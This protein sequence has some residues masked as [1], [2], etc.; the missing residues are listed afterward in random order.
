V[1]SDGAV[2][3]APRADLVRELDTARCWALAADGEGCWLGT[4]NP[5]CVYRWR[6]GGEIEL[7]AETDSFMVLSLLPD[8]E[9][10]VLAGTGPDGRVLQIGADG[11]T[12][13]TW[14][15]QARYVWALE[16]DGDGAVMAGTGPD[17][18]VFRLGE[19]PELMAQI[20]QPHVLDLLFDGERLLA[21]GGDNEGGV[22][23]ITGGGW[24]RDIF[25][26]EE[27]ACTG[28]AVDEQGRLI[29]STAESGKAWVL[30]PDGDCQEVLESEGDLL[31]VA[32]AGGRAW[33]ATAHDGELVTID[34]RGECA[35]A[36][37]DKLAAE[38]TCI[39]AGEDVVFAASGP[40]ARL[41]R[42][43]LGAV[44]EGVYSSPA[45]DAERRSRWAS[46]WW[47]AEVPEGAQLQVEAR[48]G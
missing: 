15:L 32:F 3:L 33:V 31:D 23:E 26:S 8:G 36:A 48:S 28:L 14:E 19:A 41:W 37:R 44:T 4:A 38:V 39:A 46:A 20:S 22:F 43:D 27:K 34:D 1:R 30:D 18:R 47:D 16:R 40:P 10:G 2:L 5:G 7:V 6:A 25:G 45:L 24:A 29:I 9:G 42:L 21:A 35:V 13:R 12:S 17:G 11:S